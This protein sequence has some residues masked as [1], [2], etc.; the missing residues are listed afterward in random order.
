M[1]YQKMDGT[2]VPAVGTLDSPAHTLTV[3]RAAGDI[4][5]GHI[6]QAQPTQIATFTYTRPTPD[7]LSLDGQLNGHHVTLSLDQ[8]DLNSFPLRS[9]K[10]KWVQDYPHFS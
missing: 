7:R 5:P 10:F 6:A 4:L 9:T 2:L 8:V 1:T 3:S